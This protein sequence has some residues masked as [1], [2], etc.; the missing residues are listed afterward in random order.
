MANT[1]HDAGSAGCDRPAAIKGGKVK[2]R[3]KA[4]SRLR[5]T[6]AEM[7]AAL[8]VLLDSGQ[9]RS[10][11]EKSTHGLL[12]TRILNAAAKVRKFAMKLTET[13]GP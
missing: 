4:Q 1:A 8:R 11:Y 12:I 10:V 6:D 13:Q 9:L 5:V 2:A 7:R 3:L